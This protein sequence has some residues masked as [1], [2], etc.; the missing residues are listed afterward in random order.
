MSVKALHN[1][2]AHIVEATIE[3]ILRH[4]FDEDGKALNALD[5]PMEFVVDVLSSLSIDMWS[6][7]QTIRK[8]HCKLSDHFQTSVMRWA[9]VSTAGT[10]SCWHT[11]TDGLGTMVEVQNEEGLKVWFVG[12]ERESGPSFSGITTFLEEFDT[13][14]PNTEIWNVE[15]IVL[16]PSVKL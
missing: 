10:H 11:D 3:D 1:L 16:T 9:L 15:A 14:M 7:Q 5:L 4:A 8:L 12:V 6:W 2:N 13:E